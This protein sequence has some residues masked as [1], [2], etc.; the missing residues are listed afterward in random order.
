M[1]NL[2]YLLKQQ[3]C[4]KVVWALIYEN[5]FLLTI[6]NQEHIKN[7]FVDF[8]TKYYVLLWLFFDKSA[9]HYLQ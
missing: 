7:L 4:T 9:M 6:K 8:I 3:K 2:K 5:Y 1:A